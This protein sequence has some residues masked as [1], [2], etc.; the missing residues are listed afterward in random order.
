MRMHVVAVFSGLL[1]LLGGCS[2]KTEL[3]R[4]QIV[5]IFIEVEEHDT[6]YLSVVTYKSKRIKVIAPEPM[7]VGYVELIE[8][9]RNIKLRILRKLDDPEYDYEALYPHD[10][11]KE[12]EIG[13]IIEG[14]LRGKDL[15]NM[16]THH[17]FVKQDGNIIKLVFNDPEMKYVTTHHSRFDSTFIKVKILEKVDNND[18]DYIGLYLETIPPD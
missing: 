18:F 9:S 14:Q 6:H 15:Q 8:S 11:Y 17:R 12:Y 2:A 3:Q 16:L 10:E 5:D 13:E 4:G 1:I 7:I